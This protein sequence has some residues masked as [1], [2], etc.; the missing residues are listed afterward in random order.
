MPNNCKECE[1]RNCLYYNH[2][3][4][5]I[6]DETMDYST[7]RNPKCPL[8]STD[9]MKNE[10]LNYSFSVVNPSDTYEYVNVVNLANI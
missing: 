4:W 7:A 5:N 2:V 8:K 9:E 3:W 10:L 1:N 6:D